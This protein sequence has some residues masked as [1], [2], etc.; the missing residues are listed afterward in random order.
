MI[1]LLS[2]R[3]GPPKRSRVEP[4]EAVALALAA[5]RRGEVVGIGAA[6]TEKVADGLA[7]A[8]LERARSHPD[9]VVVRGADPV[10]A[11]RAGA[12]L[13]VLA[14]VARRR[15]APGWEVVDRLAAGATQAGAA[16]ALGVTR[17]A[18]SQ[19]AVAAGWRHER[20][21]APLVADLLAARSDP[22]PAPGV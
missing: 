18:V 11:A 5:A 13:A 22:A 16:R 10:S 12:V 17:Q 9:R 6:P 7:R 2:S 3:T 4:T 15:T 1:V 19:R 8:A 21:L 14:D 20:D